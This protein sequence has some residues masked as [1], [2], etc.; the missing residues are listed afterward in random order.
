MMDDLF[1]TT[2]VK[3][4]LGQL[5]SVWRRD[6]VSIGFLPPPADVNN[7]YFPTSLAAD[8]EAFSGPGRRLCL[9]TEAG[10]ADILVFKDAADP[11]Q[12]KRYWELRRAGRDASIVAWLW[13]NHTA[14]MVNMRN[15]LACDVFFLSHWFVRDIYVNPYSILGGHVPLCCAQWSI[16]D[17]ARNESLLET[18]ERSDRLYAGYVQYHWAARSELLRTLKE[19]MPEADVLLMEAD[20]RSRYFSQDPDDRLH[21][22]TRYKTS[23]VLPINDDLSTRVF[24]GLFAGQVILLP[25]NVKDFDSVV[26]LEVQAQLPVVRFDRYDIDAVREAH[27]RAVRLFDESGIEG[28]RRR[29]RFV[30]EN[31]MLVHRLKAM[32]AALDDLVAGRLLCRFLASANGPCGWSLEEK[33]SEPLET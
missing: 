4:I 14:P 28:V 22:W 11:G 17:G 1:P 3:Q 6:T 10:D 7:R 33:D 26:P 30:V 5:R 27:L 13:D 25:T 21:E 18:G 15:V 32:E 19:D 2:R 16:A 9:A 29:H 20:D 8:F 24:D 23:L 31:H 12:A